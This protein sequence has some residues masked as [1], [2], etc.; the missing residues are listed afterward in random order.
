MT[1]RFAHS[2]WTRR[3]SRV[4]VAI[5]VLI[6]TIGIVV[7]YPGSQ[8]LSSPA[9][10]TMDSAFNAGGVG[11]NSDVLAVAMQPDGR[12]V[13]SGFFTSYNGDFAA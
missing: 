10:G 12:I 3:V 9:D 6:S 13:I 4:I 2:D 5:A 1:C 8:S 7:V 11:P